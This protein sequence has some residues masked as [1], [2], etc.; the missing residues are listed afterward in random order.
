ML[1]TAQGKTLKAS[2]RWDSPPTGSL[3]AGTPQPT[4]GPGGTNR[5]LL[6]SPLRRRYGDPRHFPAARVNQS[7][8]SFQPHRRQHSHSLPVASA[9]AS[10]SEPTT[11]ST[12]AQP[13]FPRLMSRRRRHR[14]PAL[15]TGAEA[16]RPSFSPS[17]ARKG[18]QDTSVH[19]PIPPHPNNQSAHHRRRKTRG[20]RPSSPLPSLET[21]AP[22]SAP[23]TVPGPDRTARHHNQT[24]ARDG[25]C[26]RRKR[27]SLPDP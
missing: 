27:P 7:D 8:R 21:T 2:D 19:S 13:L 10:P 26:N 4:P 20:R 23:S 25:V 1:H 15:P 3:M 9:R 17:R 5:G 16:R 18:P 24:V 14:D 12:R 6:R 11:S 22:S